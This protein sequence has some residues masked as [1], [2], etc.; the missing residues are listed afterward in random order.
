MVAFDFVSTP[1]LLLTHSPDLAD[2]GAHHF[3]E[4]IMKIKQKFASTYSKTLFSA[5]FDSP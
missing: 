1:E 2:G 5:D 3:A 4:T